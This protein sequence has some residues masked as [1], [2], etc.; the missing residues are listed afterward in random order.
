MDVFD[1]L[2]E[3][4]GAKPPEGVKYSLTVLE[5]DR[6][7]HWRVSAFGGRVDD[8]AELEALAIDKLGHL[9]F[10][11]VDDLILDD[12]GGKAWKGKWNCV[13]IYESQEN[14]RVVRLAHLGPGQNTD[15]VYAC[16]GSTLSSPKQSG[17]TEEA[18]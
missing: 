14:G 2:A 17:E 5:Y 6:K 16:G 1:F 10:Q 9:D 7:P 18:G 12:I 4:T 13:Y 15:Q 11:D 8:P 3:E